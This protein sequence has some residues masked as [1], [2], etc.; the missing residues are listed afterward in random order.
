MNSWDDQFNPTRGPVFA[1]RRGAGTVHLALCPDDE[2]LWHWMFLPDDLPTVQEVPTGFVDFESGEHQMREVEWTP[3]IVHAENASIV[4]SLSPDELKDMLGFLSHVTEHA[5]THA[6]E[7]VKAMSRSHNDRQWDA[8][9]EQNI[10]L[11]GVLVV[12]ATV[13]NLGRKV[14]EALDTNPSQS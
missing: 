9:A 11:H 5:V 12:R 10:E 1:F 7:L 13:G 14:Y 3:Q 4:T 2:D 8:L 6:G